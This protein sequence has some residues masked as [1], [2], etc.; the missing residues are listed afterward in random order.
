[1]GSSIVRL[2]RISSILI[3]LIVA[4]SFLVFAA[5]QTK[6]ASA[7]Q[8]EQVAAITPGSAPPPKTQSGSHEGTLRKDLDDASNAL[9]SP[10]AGIVSDSSSEWATRGGRL[11]LALLVYGFGLG[12]LARTLRVRL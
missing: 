2:L 7:N 4:S 6:A 3:C 9:T 1:V 8:Q 10:F 11:I 5:N 12:F